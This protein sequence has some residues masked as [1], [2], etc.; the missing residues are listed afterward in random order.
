M[1][2]CIHALQVG[3]VITLLGREGGNFCGVGSGHTAND[4]SSGSPG[5]GAMLSS[6]SGSCYRADSSADNRAPCKAVI[7]CLS[8]GLPANLLVSILPAVIIIVAKLIEAHA[9]AR[10]RHN[11]RA[12]GQ[13]RAA[14]NEQ[15]HH[16]EQGFTESSHGSLLGHYRSGSGSGSTCSQPPGHCFT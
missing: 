1:S 9:G 5:A 12:I 11:T 4:Q 7:A 10:H 16:Q 13:G 6:K 15:G 14:A 2:L 3:I 8:G